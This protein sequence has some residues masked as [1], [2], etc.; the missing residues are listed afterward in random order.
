MCFDV[1]VEQAPDADRQG[2]MPAASRGHG[3]KL[4]FDELRTTVIVRQVE[5]LF[6][7]HA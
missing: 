6:G 4:S 5:Q 7:S 1:L 2:A 3:N